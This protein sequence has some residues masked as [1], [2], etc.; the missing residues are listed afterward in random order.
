[1]MDIQKTSILL[2]SSQL[3]A[4]VS[5]SSAT[6]CRDLS[7]S[8]CSNVSSQRASN[9]RIKHELMDTQI[10]KP[11]EKNAPILAAAPFNPQASS[12]FVIAKKEIKQI[13]TRYEYTLYTQDGQWIRFTLDQNDKRGS[14][15]SVGNVIRFLEITEPKLKYGTDGFYLRYNIAFKNGEQ[16]HVDGQIHKTSDQFNFGQALNP[17]Q[18][19]TN[20][21]STAVFAFLF[22][23]ANYQKRIVG[24]HLTVTLEDGSAYSLQSDVHAYFDPENPPSPIQ[25]GNLIYVLNNSLVVVDNNGIIREFP[26]A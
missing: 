6:P 10:R 13:G 17:P 21:V 2:T 4:P 9:R 22:D 25:K 1:M 12:E 20:V 24:I 3:T 26:Y 11:L 18:H 8:E 5:L 14:Q 16:L 7:A 15:T 23:G 19:V